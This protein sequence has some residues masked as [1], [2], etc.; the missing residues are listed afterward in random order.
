MFISNIT[1][2]GATPAL[3]HTLAFNEARTRTI[4]ENIANIQTPNYRAKQLDVGE[5]QAALKSALDDR[6]NPRM[7][8]RIPR[9]GQFRQTDSGRLEVT[10]TLKPVDNLMSYDGTNLS[11]EKEMA[12]LAKTGMRHDLA[13]ELLRGKYSGL[14]KA[15]RGTV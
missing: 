5:F 14:R 15:I 8:F 4:A 9:S 6:E 2:R 7:P 1:D 13:V 12:E 11:I 3:V 10:P